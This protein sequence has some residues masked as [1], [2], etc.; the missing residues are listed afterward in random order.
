M[1]ETHVSEAN[2]LFAALRGEAKRFSGV[3]TLSTEDVLQHIYLM[4]LEHAAGVDGYNPL[5]GTPRAFIM[6]RMWGLME[7]W[8][9]RELSIDQCETYEAVTPE[10]Q[11]PAIDIQLIEA[12]QRC[13]KERISDDLERFRC[14]GSASL[15]TIHVL[16]AI[17]RSQHEIAR[18]W[19]KGSG[20]MRETLRKQLRALVQGNDIAG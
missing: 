1:S 3:S 19:G 15:S 20:R 13:V 7:R 12:A 6:G 17:G 8:R 16:A 9:G 11:S 10:L 14:A 5:L 2:K 18:R 4:C